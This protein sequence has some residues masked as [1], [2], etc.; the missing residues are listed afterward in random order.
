[1]S[2]EIDKYK[3][4]IWIVIF[5]AFVINTVGMG[6]HKIWD[7]FYYWI[8]PISTTLPYIVLALIARV[9]ISRVIKNDGYVLEPVREFI[10]GSIMIAAFSL[11]IIFAG[12]RGEAS[13]SALAFAFTPIVFLFIGF[14]GHVIGTRVSRV[15]QSRERNG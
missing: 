2:V 7:D 9:R 6:Q 14:F 12:E 10:G 13:G 15:I 4:L 1:M 3:K 11:W 5:A 8:D